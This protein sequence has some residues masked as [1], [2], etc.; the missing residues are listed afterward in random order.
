M[1]FCLIPDRP[2][3]AYLNWW[4]SR[5]TYA[6]DRSA[7]TGNFA[8]IDVD[9]TVLEFIGQ[10]HRISYNDL[11]QSEATDSWMTTY[12]IPHDRFFCVPIVVHS[13]ANTNSLFGVVMTCVGVQKKRF[14]RQK[15][16]NAPG[17]RCKYHLS[18]CFETLLRGTLNIYLGLRSFV[19]PAKISFR[20]L[21]CKWMNK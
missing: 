5:L 8:N 16:R 18:H 1:I 2:K 6:I 4:C 11:K 20:Y 17:K 9:V 21:P 7:S 19:R 14:I 15:I 10:F 13:N 12:R 3:W